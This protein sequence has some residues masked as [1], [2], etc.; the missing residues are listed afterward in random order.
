MEQRGFDGASRPEFWLAHVRAGVLLTE[1]GCSLVLLYIL[2]EPGLEH[3]AVLLG[4]VAALM[5][6]TGAILLLPLRTIISHPRSAYFFYAWS[7]TAVTITSLG[8]LLSGGSRSPIVAFYF[9]I[10]VY[11]AT[12][13]PPYAQHRIAVGMVGVYALMAAR[14][15]VELGAS[16]VVAGALALTAWM[17]SIA[18]RNQWGQ[19]QE[20][21]RLARVDGLTGCL[22]QRAFREVLDAE[23]ERARRF[24]HPLSLVLVDL[25]DFKQVND[26]VGHLAGDATLAST[27]EMLRGAVR[28]IDV[29]GRIGGDEFALLLIETH[30][31]RAVEAAERVRRW[32]RTSIAPDSTTVSIGVAQLASGGSATSLLHD[33]DAALYAAKRAGRD[34][35]RGHGTPTRDALPDAG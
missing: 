9:L 8:A 35:V 18:A 26:E 13:Y 33:A 34:Q 28:G 30:L 25:D 7:T 10:M 14:D 21:M 3:T 15:P 5:A 23:V 12:A 16:A 2:T 6:G 19:L 1:I 32:V 11:A 27:G 29:V 4:L 31:D 17:S 22:N 20:Q 24:D